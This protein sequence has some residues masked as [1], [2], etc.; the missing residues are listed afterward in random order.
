MSGEGLL[1][2]PTDA[3]I[4]RAWR[5]WQSLRF[6]LAAMYGLFAVVLQP[7]SA[8]LAP[9][10]ARTVALFFPAAGRLLGSG[11]DRDA[12]PVTQAPR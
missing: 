3:C 2:I 6:F 1:R 5:N 12:L 9:L 11:K 4:R 10:V 8:K 7:D